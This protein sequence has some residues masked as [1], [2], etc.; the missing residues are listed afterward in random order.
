MG[1]LKTAPK[2]AQ[3]NFANA[4]VANGAVG[5][6]VRAAA[7]ELGNGIR[8]NAVSPLSLKILPNIFLFFQA[9]FQLLCN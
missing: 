6:V 7:I 5:A 8:I 4:S 2:Q 9:I 3:L 1:R